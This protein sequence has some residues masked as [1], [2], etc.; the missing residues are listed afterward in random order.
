VDRYTSFSAKKPRVLAFY[1][2]NFCGLPKAKKDFLLDV[3]SKLA[4]AGKIDGVRISTRPDSVDC[5]EAE[6][7]SSRG[8][9]FVEL[10][11]QSMDD[12]I[13]HRALRG[14][15]AADVANA[16]RALKLQD[17]GTG[18]HLMLGLPGADE[19]NDL[20]SA[21]RAAELMPD[22]VRLHPTLVLK[23]TGLET[24]CLAGRYTPLTLD[25][26]VKRL[27]AAIDI[28]EKAGIKV[29]RVGIHGDDEILSGRALV[30]GPF[31]PS[32]R[33]L[34]EKYRASGHHL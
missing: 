26:A 29:I 25:E 4:G 33:T 11:A 28:F 20:S 21:R 27:A 14:H 30:A 1:G 31:H 2:G 34:V 6:Y 12:V 32:L 3:A 23:G 5:G 16:V 24:E 17:V 15:T 18:L 7:L 9:G 22:T 8:V 13:L 10:G 19:E